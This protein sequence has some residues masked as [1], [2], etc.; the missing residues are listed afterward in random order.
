M[1]VCPQ[2]Q[3][4]RLV[5][6]GSAAGTPQK[7]CRP[8]GYPF[9]RPTLR[10]TPLAMK[11]HAV[12]LSLSGLSRHRLAFLLRVSV[13]SVLNGLRTFAQ[14]PDAKPA[15][16]SRAILWPEFAAHKYPRR[17]EPLCLL[18]RGVEKVRNT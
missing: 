6:N 14:E 11:V 7:L 10:G 15:P 12:L 2:C 1:Q 16:T 4:A 5:H 13:R 9:T 3:R 8:C 17:V 18:G